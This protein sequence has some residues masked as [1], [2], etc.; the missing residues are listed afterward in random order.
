[1][2]TEDDVVEAVCR[3]L[4]AAGWTIVARASTVERGPDVLADR[5]GRRLVVE[6]KGET[7]NRPAS[8]RFGSPFN[9]G[10]VHDHVG[11]AVLE[12]LAAVSAGHVGAI[13]LPDER[14]H[15]RQVGRIAA[16][17]AAAGVHVLWVLA[18]GTVEGVGALSW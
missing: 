9:A 1:M 15:R 13:A 18:D 11:R 2:L 5:D 8:N 3:A 10:Q 4:A 7:S 12:A 16:G 14:N 17:L 6:A